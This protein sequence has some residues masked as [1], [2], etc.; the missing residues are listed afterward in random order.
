MFLGS[1]IFDKRRSLNLTQSDLADGVC[2]QNT[3]SKMEKHNMTPQID[4]LIKLCHRLDLSLNEVFSD[5]SSDATK[6]QSLILDGIEE[7]VL[8][9]KLV[10]VDERLKLVA[11]ELNA[12]DI[13][14]YD[15]ISA[16]LKFYREEY[17]ESLNKLDNVL[18]KTTSDNGNIY[19]LMAYLFKGMIYSK[20]EHLDMATYFFKLVSDSIQTSFEIANAKQVE[21]LFICKV[22]GKSFIRLGQLDAALEISKRGLV[23]ANEN[24]SSYFIDE[25]NYSV[26]LILL[27][28]KENPQIIKK[29]KDLAYY[30]AELLNHKELQQEILKKLD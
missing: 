8:S 11:N 23:Y 2:N 20:Q 22:L 7:E 25:L 14:Q 26:A 3:I 12:K 17:D 4:V 1:V 30:C 5:F 10:Q 9:K 16:V 24:H 27:T 13:P 15:F 21:I 18:Q 29:Y 6:E 28:K 19:T